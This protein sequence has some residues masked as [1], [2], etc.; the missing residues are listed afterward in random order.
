MFTFYS[1]LMCGF[2]SMSASQ[3]LFPKLLSYKTG[4]KII[5]NSRLLFLYSEWILLTDHHSVS[6]GRCT[7]D[8]CKA[9]DPAANVSCNVSSQAVS[10]NVELI[11][12]LLVV[13]LHHATCVLN[14]KILY[15]LYRP[16]ILYIQSVVSAAS[17]VSLC[18]F[19]CLLRHFNFILWLDWYSAIYRQ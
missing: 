17:C 6:S 11:G 10:D 8:T 13:T 9:R 16:I 5:Y 7:C 14:S 15:L 4:S 3:K 18:P 12:L 1:G 2:T 19:P